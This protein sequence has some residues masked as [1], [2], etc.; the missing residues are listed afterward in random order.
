MPKISFSDTIPLEK[1]IPQYNCKDCIHKYYINEDLFEC[2]ILGTYH[3]NKEIYNSLCLKKATSL[4]RSAMCVGAFTINDTG[5]FEFTGIYTVGIFKTPSIDH[6]CIAGIYK[7]FETK[8][9]KIGKPIRFF[10]IAEKRY[11]LWN[12]ITNKIDIKT[13]SEIIKELNANNL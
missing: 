1:S 2:T 8:I 7:E 3:F 13:A 10:L 5:T 11:N 4:N 12:I 6:N 9:K